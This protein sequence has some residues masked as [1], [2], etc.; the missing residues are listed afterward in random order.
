MPVYDLRT[1]IEH[2]GAQ[3]I[4][5]LRLVEDF[6]R[7]FTRENFW[8]ASGLEDLVLAERKVALERV[9]SEGEA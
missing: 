1:R 4:S 6:L 5:Y 3:Q 8:W 9:L 2:N 7:N